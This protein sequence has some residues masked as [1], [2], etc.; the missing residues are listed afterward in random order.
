MAT[1]RAMEDGFLAFAP[2]DCFY[3]QF[4]INLPILLGR[5]QG[6]STKVQDILGPMIA[7]T[8]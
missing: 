8:Y 4:I 5:S 3:F 7:R 6:H 2:T 1:I